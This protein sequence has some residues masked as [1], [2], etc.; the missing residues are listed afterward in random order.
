M[1]QY[2]TLLDE[3][4]A[5]EEWVEEVMGTAAVTISEGTVLLYY[6]EKKLKQD[7]RDL[8]A[9]LV[10]QGVITY[11]HTTLQTELENNQ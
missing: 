4:I 8:K 6:V 5:K 10:D 1:N 2:Q 7:W 11:L 3:D 9:E